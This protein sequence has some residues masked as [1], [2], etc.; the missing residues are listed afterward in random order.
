SKTEP[1]YA[2]N[3]VCKLPVATNSSIEL[4]KY[5]LFSLGLIYKE[6]YRY[7]KAGVLVTDIVPETQVQGCLF[8]HTARE[9]QTGI[10]Q[11]MDQ[12]NSKYGP[13][14]LKLAIQGSGSKWKLRQE[15]LSPCYTT[16]LSDIITV[17]V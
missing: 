14:T 6:G 17:L 4:V 12:I 15:N 10:M 8:D 11:T 9:K 2:Q 16:R 5:A 1:Q 3:F 13:N 7:K